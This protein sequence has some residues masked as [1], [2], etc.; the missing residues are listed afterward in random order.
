VV[1]GPTVTFAP[2]R[3]D[4]Q[5]S[6]LAQA[7]R[8]PAWLQL[9]QIPADS[10]SVAG[11]MRHLLKS[12]GLLALLIVAQQ[13]AVIHELSHLPGSA[14]DAVR[15]DSG[16]AAHAACALCAAYAQA[17]TP[18]LSHSIAS[19]LLG[20]AMHVRGAVPFWAAADAAVPPPRSRGPP[21]RS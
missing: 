14:P 8:A 3:S 5:D 13:G 20:R 9:L 18:A 10:V 16:G 19:P 21:F 15:L 2:A 17:A 11:P 6:L 4:A 12:L 7:P 1:F